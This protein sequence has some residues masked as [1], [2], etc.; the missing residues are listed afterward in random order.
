MAQPQKDLNSYRW[1]QSRW[2]GSLDS[3]PMGFT[4][5][6]DCYLC[7]RKL[8]GDS[9]RMFRGEYAGKVVCGDCRYWW[10]HGYYPLLPRLLDG[11]VGSVMD[12]NDIDAVVE[13]FNTH[14]WNRIRRVTCRN[15][16]SMQIYLEADLCR[17]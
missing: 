1:S 6:G 3:M 13:S 11:R 5:T 17:D 12:S 15:M 14:A 16:R 2:S 8:I 10:R 7:E 9:F 4:D